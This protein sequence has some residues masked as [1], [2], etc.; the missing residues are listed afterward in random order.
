LLERPDLTLTD[1]ALQCGFHSSAHFSHRFRQVYSM[2][3]S[4]CRRGRDEISELAVI[5]TDI[6]PH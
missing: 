6:K 2:T 1:I 3:P 4:A 5:N